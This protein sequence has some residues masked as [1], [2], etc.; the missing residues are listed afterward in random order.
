[1]KPQFEKKQDTEDEIFSCIQYEDS[2]CGKY[3]TISWR[4]SRNFPFVRKQRRFKIAF[5][6]V[7]ERNAQSHNN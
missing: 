6:I 2:N 5:G 3:S 4:G 7:F 1:M